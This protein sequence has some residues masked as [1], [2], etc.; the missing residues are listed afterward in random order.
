MPD[1]PEHCKCS[2]RGWRLLQ[3]TGALVQEGPRAGGQGGEP[4]AESE[5]AQLLG[6]SSGHERLQGEIGDNDG[7]SE[8]D[9]R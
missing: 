9:L 7:G 2:G 1:D 5:L 3:G 4:S 8:Q 6:R